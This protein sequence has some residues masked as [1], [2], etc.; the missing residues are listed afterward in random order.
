[1]VDQT[2]STNDDLLKERRRNPASWPHLTVLVAHHQNAG[3][4]RL[5]REWVTPPG[6]ALTLSMVVEPLPRP[7]AQW[8][9]ISL[10][11]G[12]AVVRTLRAAGLPA[13]LKWPNDVVLSPPPA[14]DGRAVPPALVTTAVPGWG[15]DRKVAGVLTQAVGQPGGGGPESS[16]AGPESSALIVG[17]GVNVA[18][19]ELPVPWA[20]SLLVAGAPAAVCTPEGLLA[21]LE[22]ELVG[23][24]E[25]WRHSGLSDLIPEIADSCVT[26]GREVLVAGLPGREDDVRGRALRLTDA[27]E[28]VLRIARPGDPAAGAGD[29]VADATAGPAAPPSPEID[30]EIIVAAGDVHH[31]RAL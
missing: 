16:A 19:R 3:R 17:V 14:P 4:G 1:M 24:V 18:Q 25:Q 22:P 9:G 30:G 29:E 13:G 31:L 23:A 8:P 7:P 26:L 15:G 27:G 21:A 12:L 6:Q 28:L 20:T 11:V 5:G 10:V 2:G